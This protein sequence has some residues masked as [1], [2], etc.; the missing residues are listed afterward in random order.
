M[1]FLTSVISYCIASQEKNSHT[2]KAE[3]QQTTKAKSEIVRTKNDGEELIQRWHCCATP[4]QFAIITFPGKWIALVARCI[5]GRRSY[6]RDCIGD[7]AIRLYGPRYD[8][9]EKF[10]WWPIKLSGIRVSV[11]RLYVCTYVRACVRARACIDA[12]RMCDEPAPLT[13]TKQRAGWVIGITFIVWPATLPHTVLQLFIGEKTVENEEK[14]T[15]KRLPSRKRWISTDGKKQ[16]MFRRKIY[17]NICNILEK[18][19]LSR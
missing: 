18:D 10:V 6:G 3:F 1:T 7:F 12:T 4:L 19:M 11:A 9:D 17:F 14:C 15:P 2:K 8:P 16:I 13:L 5:L